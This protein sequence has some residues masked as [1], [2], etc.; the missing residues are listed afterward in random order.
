MGGFDSG[1]SSSK[2]KGLTIFKGF[3]VCGMKSVKWKHT[4]FSEEI[5]F[6]HSGGKAGHPYGEALEKE[7]S[8]CLTSLSNAQM[9]KHLNL[10]K[11]D[12]WQ[13]CIGNS[14]YLKVTKTTLLSWVI[15]DFSFFSDFPFTLYN[16]V[17]FS[18]LLLLF[19]YSFLHI[20]QLEAVCPFSPFLFSLG[21]WLT[22]SSSPPL[23]HPDY[24]CGCL[25]AAI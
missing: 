15:L 4:C 14:I 3:L 20:L 11:P 25:F 10:F 12:P 1:V 8:K 6:T 22:T 13:P 17:T 18:C 19:A 21:L 7:M 9:I 2:W 23:L 24:R 16:F 5:I